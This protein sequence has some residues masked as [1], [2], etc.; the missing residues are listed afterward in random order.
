[1]TLKQKKQFNITSSGDR[2]NVIPAWW[3]GAEGTAHTIPYGTVI[4][5]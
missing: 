4:T 3:G 5:V 1:V 2:N